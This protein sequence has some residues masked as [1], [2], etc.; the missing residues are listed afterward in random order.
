MG[1]LKELKEAIKNPPPERLASIEYRSHA[2]NI[3]GITAVTVILIAKGYWYI[4]LAFIFGVG[5]SYSQMMSS[6]AK[7]K[8]IREFNPMVQPLLEDEKSPTRRRRRIINESLG[9][10]ISLLSSIISL[11]IS[12]VI[13]NPTQEGWYIKTAFVFLVFLLWVIIYFFPIYWIA[14]IVKNQKG[15]KI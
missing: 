9:K 6:Y 10:G 12:M 4:V 14:L 11:I 8:A 1:K 15:G 3:L 7:Y 2:M 5:V 13:L